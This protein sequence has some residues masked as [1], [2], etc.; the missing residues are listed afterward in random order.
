MQNTRIKTEVLTN[1]GR[2]QILQSNYCLS[3]VVKPDIDLVY[4]VQLEA[5][6]QELSMKKTSRIKVQ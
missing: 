5:L 2:F 3:V 6:A 1:I 4:V